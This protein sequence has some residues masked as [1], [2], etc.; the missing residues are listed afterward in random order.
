MEETAQIAAPARSRSTL[1]GA[2]KAAVVLIALGP[3]PSA[4]VLKRLPEDDVD[5]ITTEIARMERIDPQI[6]E[7]ILAEFQQFATAHTV[8]AKGGVDYANRLLVETYGSETAKRLMERIMRSVNQGMLTFAHFRKV[9]PQQLAKFIQDEHPQTIALILSHLESNHA[10]ALLGSLPEE[11]RADVAVRMADL[12]QISPEVVRNIANVIGHKL[13][14]LGE[15]SREACGGVRAVANMLNRLDANICG[16]IL[17]DLENNTP[18]LF[19]NIRRFMFVFEDLERLDGA[20]IKEL[21]GRVERKT[22]LMALK[23]TGESLQQKFLSAQSQRGA[24]MMLEDMADMG[25]VKLKDVD[26]AQQEIITLARAL[27][28]EGV[29]SLTSSAADQ[30]VY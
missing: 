30:Y 25:P 11:I 6:A 19:E 10:A 7:E 29:I 13:R 9:D 1:S 28:K 4:Q 23:G 8:L 17:T 27:E 3:G 14:N 20:G 21:I 16:R 15:L 22:L 12:D 5:I 24:Q 18:T 2:Q 26:A